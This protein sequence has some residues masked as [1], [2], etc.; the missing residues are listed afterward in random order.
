MANC[1]GVLQRDATH[2]D[3]QTLK[4]H[5]LAD[6]QALSKVFETNIEAIRTKLKNTES[7]GSL[8]KEIDELLKN[9]TVEAIRKKKDQLA[10]QNERLETLCTSFTSL[11][12][13]Y[14]AL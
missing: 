14:L 5:F 3:V 11:V 6:L 8:K 7:I 1:Y 10:L 13:D 12:T 4:V 2:E 9:Q